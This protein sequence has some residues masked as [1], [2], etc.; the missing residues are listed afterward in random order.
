MRKF[1]LPFLAI[2]SIVLLALASCK[3]NGFLSATTVSNLN[4]GS[5]FADS[6]YTNN[7]LASIYSQIGF[8][9]A[10]NE[11]GNGGLDAASDESQAN[12]I[13]QSDANYWA[14]GS[15]NAA[16]VTSSVYTTCYAQIRAV[17]QLLANIGQTKLSLPAGEVG[18]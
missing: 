15:I 8:D 7:F 18:S 3:K 14:Q 1:Y 2:F 12:G 13:T 17:N 10:G 11:F 5:V 9:V 6:V 4:K 16:Q